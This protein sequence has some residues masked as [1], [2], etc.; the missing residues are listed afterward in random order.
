M[1]LF[2]KNFFLK[3]LHLWRGRGEGGIEGWALEYAPMLFSRVQ[4][5]YSVQGKIDKCKIWQETELKNTNKKYT[6]PEI[7]FC[8]TP[9]PCLRWLVWSFD[10]LYDYYVIFASHV[11]TVWW[12]G[13]ESALSG[14]FQIAITLPS[15]HSSTKR[16]KKLPNAQRTVQ[17][18]A[19]LLLFNLYWSLFMSNVL[20]ILLSGNFLL[21]FFKGKTILFLYGCCTAGGFFL[22]CTLWAYG[23]CNPFKPPNYLY[24]ALC[25]CVLTDELQLPMGERGNVNLQEWSCFVCV[26]IC[27][28]TILL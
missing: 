16:C 4:Y 14:W 18:H 22:I 10:V 12:G 26:H 25:V 5:T 8:L 7:W 21:H 28:N 23:E 20:K 24:L 11:Y 17:T 1:G 6:M 2:L 27:P 9:L 3:I 19:K 13:F 15:K